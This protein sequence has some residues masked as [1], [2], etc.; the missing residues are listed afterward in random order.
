MLV[1]VKEA[2]YSFDDKKVNVWSI[3]Y[4]TVQTF[5]VNKTDSNLHILL[6]QDSTLT[7]YFR[8]ITY[9]FFFSSSSS[10]CLSFNALSMFL[11]SI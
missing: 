3:V 6:E 4:L 10:D 8:T 11:Y 2:V 9:T 7:H 5:S 1:L